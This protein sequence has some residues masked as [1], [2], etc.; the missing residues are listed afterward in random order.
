MP[1]VKTFAQACKHKGLDPKTILP[2]VSSFPKEHQKALL[3][4]A[5]AYIIVAVLN[6]DAVFDYND[7]NQEKWVLWYWLN[8]PGFRLRDAGYDNT[9]SDVGPRLSFVSR[10]VALHANTYFGKSVF[11]HIFTI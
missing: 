7:Y 8:K 4:T 11:K 10:E 1:L 6:D 3:A 2:D 5:K 9:D